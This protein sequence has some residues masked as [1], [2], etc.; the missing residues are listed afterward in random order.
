MKLE[1]N[2]FQISWQSDDDCLRNKR[3]Y[4]QRKSDGFSV[5]LL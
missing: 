3:K 5:I 2:A 4:M 1:N